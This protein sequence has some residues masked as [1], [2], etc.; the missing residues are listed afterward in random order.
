MA[1]DLLTAARHDARLYATEG[2]FQE[3]ISIE[4]P[5]G[6]TNVNITGLATKHHIFFD[7]DGTVMNGKNAHINIV[8][9]QLSDLNYPV[10]DSNGEVNLINHVVN[11]AD[12]SG[13][14]KRFII[15]ENHPSETFG[16]I[17][18]ILGDLE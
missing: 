3:N 7:T 9:S 8:E 4:T 16:L 15:K 11:V 6:S 14:I 2:G 5:D 18:C 1:G 12:S 13:V 10:R 17:V